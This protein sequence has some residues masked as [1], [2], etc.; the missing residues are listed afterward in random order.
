MFPQVTAEELWRKSKRRRVS[1]VVINCPI[2]RDRNRATLTITFFTA[3]FLS[4][5]LPY[6]FTL[7]L[8]T[9]SEMAFHYPHPFFSSPGMYW[10]SW[11]VAGVVLMT[12]NATL[13][14]LFYCYRLHGF[15]AWISRCI[16]AYTPLQSK[17]RLRGEEIAT[18]EKSDIFNR[19]KYP[20]DK[21]PRS[22]KLFRPTSRSLHETS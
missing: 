6:F 18:S 1:Q 9:V 12:L 8:M 14:P 4:C 21:R 5:N 22:P 13:N 10:Y 3:I 20:I 2:Q 15:G 7:L 17:Y 19:Q 11:A 16:N